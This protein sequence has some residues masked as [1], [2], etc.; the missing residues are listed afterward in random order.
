VKVIVLFVLALAL[1]A[2]GTLVATNALNR[3]TP[4]DK[5]TMTVIGQQMKGMD[6]SLK[7]N[8]C[9]TNDFVPRLQILRAV[10]NDIEPAFAESI[11]DP[12]FNRYAADLRAAADAALASPPANCKV[13]NE[14][15]SRL[16]KA[17][18]SCHRDF[19]G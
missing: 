2:I 13:A 1:G 17:C 15:L 14:T 6:T 3:R 8:R 7:A 16:G 5:A 4:W 19:R 11:T 10:A 9:T 12:Q 18:D